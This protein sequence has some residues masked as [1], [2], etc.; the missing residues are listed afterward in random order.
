MNI[1]QRHI[2][3]IQYVQSGEYRL[4]GAQKKHLASCIHELRDNGYL[5]V[6]FCGN[7][8]KLVLTAKATCYMASIS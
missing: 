8:S 1:T 6:Q 2:E 3:A 7:H 5:A 4:V